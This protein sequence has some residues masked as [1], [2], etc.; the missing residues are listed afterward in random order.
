MDVYSGHSGDYIGLFDDDAESQGIGFTQNDRNQQI[1]HHKDG[2][3]ESSQQ[4][5]LFPG[6]EPQDLRSLD[7]E[8]SLEE[9][10]WQRREAFRARLSPQKFSSRGR[11]EGLSPLPPV[12]SPLR[13]ALTP[14][15]I[16]NGPATYS[17]KPPRQYIGEDY[18]RS[19][20]QD[21]VTNSREPPSWLLHKCAQL[22]AQIRKLRRENMEWTNR[23]RSEARTR[24]TVLQLRQ[25]VNVSE[26]QHAEILKRME[27][28]EAQAYDAET[29]A[30]RAHAEA[31]QWK[32]LADESHV[33]H[34]E[35]SEIEDM[36][37][38][39]KYDKLTV[40]HK[41]LNEEHDTLRNAFENLFE[42]FLDL[43]SK[44]ARKFRPKAT[45]AAV[46][47][48]IAKKAGGKNKLKPPPARKKKSKAAKKKKGKFGAA[49]VM[50]ATRERRQEFVATRR[51]KMSV[52][53]GDLVKDR[54][55]SHMTHSDTPAWFANEKEHHVQVLCL[56]NP[57]S[58]IVPLPWAHYKPGTAP[59]NI[60]VAYV[61][62][63]RL[64]SLIDITYR[65]AIS[66]RFGGDIDPSSEVV[67][68]IG[69]YI[70]RMRTVADVF[71][72]QLTLKYGVYT[73]IE[74]YMYGVVE[75]ILRFQD[76]NLHVEYFGR[77]VGVIDPDLYSPRMGAM[78]F[79]L[80][81]TIVDE[82]KAIELLTCVGPVEAEAQSLKAAK[83]EELI[84]KRQKEESARIPGKA[85]EARVEKGAS[86]AIKSQAQELDA[87]MRLEE[88]TE[89]TVVERPKIVTAPL[90]R[91]LQAVD[92]VFPPQSKKDFMLAWAKLGIDDELREKLVKTLRRLSVPT[93][94]TMVLD[95][96][97]LLLC[98]VDT[99]LTQNEIDIDRLCKVWRKRRMKAD[100]ALDFR[101][102]AEAVKSCSVDEKSVQRPNIPTN[103]LNSIWEQ[104][105]G[106]NDTE[107]DFA[108]G[109][110]FA[111][112]CSAYGIV[113]PPPPPELKPG[114]EAGN[115][116]K[117]RI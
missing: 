22:E 40:D 39:P 78:F 8:S 95:V 100:K 13:K 56:S 47:S 48:T 43:T 113:P 67:N 111:V 55:S 36:L 90:A 81:R 83:Y 23:F 101:V 30:R 45:K 92:T 109:D 10:I 59:S 31:T 26:R 87:A 60:R 11:Q 50:D 58:S 71:R 9:V 108:V 75:A 27:H 15:S 21:D 2:W 19:I 29:S 32:K 68:E 62:Y 86:S 49:L 105:L 82:D 17:S 103:I 88:D 98:C 63:E 76:N 91:C 97:L 65:A 54:R 107:A 80:L 46:D 99:W 77:M 114:E 18:R 51:K 64:V 1:Y 85:A 16:L 28:A 84:S 106:T 34:L 33:S 14:Q 61:D 3:N 115:K 35:S 53:L 69:G 66:Q 20:Q 25:N 94:Q 70:G 110:G 57:L 74:G 89:I 4:S 24:A 117:K 96:N 41:F 37:W 112:V 12:Y 6:E 73:V 5:I 104:V 116:K 79:R 93:A 42:E 44:A 102:F 7:L 52:H 72:E 38:K